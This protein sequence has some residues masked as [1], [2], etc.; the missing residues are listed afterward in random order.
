MLTKTWRYMSN[1]A[2]AAGAVNPMQS[3]IRN[4]F[5]AME[6]AGGGDKYVPMLADFIAEAN[7]VDLSGNR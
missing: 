3:A 4:A 7:G 2:N 1:L 6:A 5:A